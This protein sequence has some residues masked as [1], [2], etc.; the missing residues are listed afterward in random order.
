[1]L[2]LFGCHSQ[3]RASAVHTALGVTEE[4]GGAHAPCK[5]GLRD[6]L[7]DLYSLQNKDHPHKHTHARTHTQ[8]KDTFC[9]WGIYI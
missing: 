1:M 2:T 6:G 4:G 5:E 7:G 8:G 3:L 9:V